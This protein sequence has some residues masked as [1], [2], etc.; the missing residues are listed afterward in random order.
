MTPIEFTQQPGTKHYAYQYTS[1]G[2]KRTIQLT[3]ADGP[4]AGVA[5]E[6]AI[7]PALPWVRIQKI[8]PADN[9]RTLAFVV[10]IPADI[11]VRITS[12]VPVTQAS[13]IE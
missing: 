6:I 7:D 10:D 4:I 2:T 12:I 11:Q 5:V 9:T 1:T 13:Y 8:R 3:T